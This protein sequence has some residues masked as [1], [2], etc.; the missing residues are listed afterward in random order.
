MKKSLISMTE[1]Q[2]RQLKRKAREI[3]ISVSE[4]I[5]RIIDEYFDKKDK[6]EKDT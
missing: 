2:V 1:R 4:L 3:G 6:T 5:R